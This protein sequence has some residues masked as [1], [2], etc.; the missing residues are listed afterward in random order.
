MSFA[1]SL[2]TLK[3]LTQSVTT[4]IG[5]GLAAALRHVII[6]LREAMKWVLGLAQTFAN[7]M[8]T[9]F[10]KYEGGAKGIAMDL[11]EVD[12][13]AGDLADATGDAAG[14]LGNAADAA[15]QLRKELSVLP[16]DE[17]NQLN[18]DREATTSSG[19]NGGTGGTGGGLGDLGLGDLGM[20]LEDFLD[21]SELPEAISKW[22][23]RIKNAF[24][25]HNWFAL[26]RDIAN[27]FNEGIQYL[28][29]LLDPE[30]VMAK[31][32]PFISAFTTA[33]N[34]FIDIF[35]FNLLG[36]TIARGINDVAYIFNSWYEK[37]NFV[38]LGEKLA[39]GL[40]GLLTEGDF[41]AW[42]QALGNKF[43]IAWDIFAGFVSDEEMW[44]NLGKKL[45]D[46]LTGLNNGI[47]LNEIGSALADLANGL[48]TTLAEFAE[49]APWDDVVD[50]I[51]NGINTFINETEWDKN[52][53]KVNK[54]ITKLVDAIARVLNETHW[55]EL[56]TGIASMLSQIDWLTHLKTVAEAIVNALGGLIR[57]LVSE[58]S[59]AISMGLIAGLLLL[60][61]GSKLMAFFS[62]PGIGT[63]ITG[64]ILKSLSLSL[65]TFGAMAVASIGQALMVASVWDDIP[66]NLGNKLFGVLE[67]AFN[68][69]LRPDAV[70]RLFVIKQFE[71]L[72]GI[73]IPDVMEK[74]FSYGLTSPISTA[75]S[76]IGMIVNKVKGEK[77]PEG[78]NDEVGRV[79]PLLQATAN[80]STALF[81]TS[82]SSGYNSGIRPAI[83]TMVNNIK[84]QF[85]ETENQGASS[86]EATAWRY[87]HGFHNTTELNNNLGSIRN[88]V[89]AA[90]S[91][92]RS[93]VEQ[94][95]VDTA[96]KYGRAFSDRSELNSNLNSMQ[97]EVT[98][99][100]EAIQKAA[101]T[102]GTGAKQGVI[103]GL[104]KHAD[105]LK[106]ASNQILTT[107]QTTADEVRS[108]LDLSSDMYSL[109]SSA[110]N[111]FASGFSGVH[112]PMPHIM[113]DFLDI[114]L[115][116]QI[117]IPTISW[118]KAGGLFKGG[119][120]HV[121]G[122]GEDNRDEA[123]LPLENRKA[124]S[125]IADS[126][127]N[128]SNGS[129]GISADDIADAVVQAFVMTQSNQPDPI[130]HVEVKT[131]N[132]E[133]LARAVTR[134][135]Q[136]IDY[137]NNPT[138]KLA[139]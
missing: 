111:A 130:I 71:K 116:M 16:F 87:G 83:Q 74:G 132:D 40:N 65:P 66:T 6:F 19:G 137:R 26:G 58:P 7:F 93:A 135:Q 41:I 11:G 12:D 73:D 46:G 90:V 110:G 60:N 115:G 62:L 32:E 78:V 51:V 86:G 92:V 139:Y 95:G 14:G 121:I 138:P 36:R 69:T 56:G 48:C 105:G 18:K 55:D 49:N 21:G 136:S 99:K 88:M 125:A 98:S 85:G 38:H 84:S 134:G 63:G 17:L 82:F 122:I 43:M 97:T 4:Q 57:G 120:G 89:D 37:M 64:G 79:S 50:N 127:V 75:S 113:F 102:I 94:T 30:K 27:M 13:L 133:V 5:V 22:A 8:Q 80:H 54:F 123:V 107:A 24:L 59:G 81:G 117:P 68:A 100:F 29:D 44:H 131:E 101:E 126:I 52:G 112:I 129:L 53:Q 23:L 15:E 47:R 20:G 34:A 25:A 2:R 91:N 10:G 72:T 39:E 118:Y 61:L 31:V 33:F 35:N 77:I 1:N 109:G 3:A 128:A 96:Y 70:W 42:G 45:A 67:K 124:M 119:N 104:Q 108:A 103:H 76:L 114:G 28:Y 106:E 9:L